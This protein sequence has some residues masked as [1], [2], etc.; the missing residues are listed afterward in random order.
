[1]VSDSIYSR[2]DG[3]S[4]GTG[5]WMVD[6]ASRMGSVYQIFKSDTVQA[7]WI[8]IHPTTTVGARF[9]VKIFDFNTLTSSIY[10]SS[11]VAISSTDIGKSIRV[12]LNKV[13]DPGKYL[14]I[15]ES[16]TNVS[17]R[18][19]ISSTSKKKS[20]HG[21]SY[22]QNPGQQWIH[23]A[24]FPNLSLVF[25]VVDENCPGHI[26]ATVKNESCQGTSDGQI[27]VEAIDVNFL[28]TY[29]W[30]NGAGNIDHIDNLEAGSYQVIVTDGNNC[31]YSRVFN[32]EIAQQIAVNPIIA[33]DSCGTQKGAILLN[34]SGGQE[35]LRTFLNGNAFVNKI[36]HL[37]QGQYPINIVDDNGCDFDTTISLLGSSPLN[38]A[39]GI[40]PSSCAANNGKLSATAI[41][42]PPFKYLWNTGDSVNNIQA[43]ES[44][45]YELTVSDSIN[46]SSSVKVFL[47]D[48]NA[49]VLNLLN[50]SDVE[51]YG[52]ETGSLEIGASGINSPFSFEWSNADTSYQLVD[53]NSGEYE[54][55]VTDSLGCK[56]FGS[57]SIQELGEPFFIDFIEQGIACHNNPTGSIKC[58]V[59]GGSKPYS[60]AWT[61]SVSTSNNITNLSEGDYALTITDN[62]GC[63][64]SFSTKVYSQPPFF[65][66]V[67][68]IFGDTDGVSSL[69]ASIYLSVFGGT[70]PY[71]YAWSNG[72]RFQDL[73]NVDTGF[74]S[75]HITDQFGCSLNYEKYLSNNPLG[76]D[77]LSSPELTSTKFFPNPGSIFNHFHLISDFEIRQI[78]VRDLLGR[79]A[80]YT[81]EINGKSGQLNFFSAGVHIVTVEFE[82]GY[83]ESLRLIVF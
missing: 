9:K 83:R 78:V 8:G 20:P 33:L 73:V 53:V 56:S 34:A 71:N 47:N 6:E 63:T 1:M 7:I 28:A 54:L 26:Q 17:N 45:I 51:C 68:S 39:V 13:L 3:T 32:L 22:Y 30:S 37:S 23:L 60:F 16:E 64:L 72:N 44:G 76:V 15:L 31:I 35:P 48:S 70:P 77:Q 52:S 24:Y 43:L 80:K 50:T 62:E 58:L 38:I 82:N 18:L 2:T 49:P 5:I 21:I 65:M 29:S 12:E 66:T 40:Q 19:V 41:G 55:T 11:P 57:Y 14:F 61:P 10:S 25:P 69:D 81:C 46:C 42:T 4:D 74:Y 67:D 27:E 75:V 36:T 59:N 79:H